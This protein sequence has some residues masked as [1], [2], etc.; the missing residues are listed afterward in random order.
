[1]RKL[2][3]ILFVTTQGA[4]LNKEGETVVVSVERETKLQVP[5]HTLQGIVCFGNV[6]MSPFLMGHC[7]ERQVSVSF[8]TEYGK[9]LASV[10]GKVS[11]NVLLRR[12]QYRMADDPQM[13][14][15]IAANILTGKIANARSVLQRALRDHGE[16]MDAVRVGGV[17]S[18]LQQS[19]ERLDAMKDL[20]ALR[21]VEGDSAADYFDVFDELIV[22]Q[23]NSFV[24]DGRNRRPPQDN[25]NCLLSFVYTLLMHDVRAALE[26]VGLDPCVG[27][28]HRDRSGRAGL[29]L[30][31]MEEFRAFFAD[32]LV[33]S[34]INRLQVSAKDFEQSSCGA[35]MM[36]DAARKELLMAY[37][38]RKQEEVVHPYINESVPMGL[39]FYVQ[40]MLLAR[41][42]RGDIDGYPPFI[43]K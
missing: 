22:A 1:M 29:A 24:F 2:L 3:N 18:R 7:A 20:D 37:Q 42:I 17:V 11:G 26:V 40:A 43:W 41:F 33:L 35:V 14:A 30:D 21:G 25:V 15:K 8:L 19:V 13:S 16:K 9:F 10:Q 4:Y 38:K 6:M 27:F 32:R 12:A 5:I 28:L 31:V 39:L 23:K 36:K 34:L